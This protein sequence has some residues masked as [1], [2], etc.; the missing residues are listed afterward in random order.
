MN[1]RQRQLITISHSPTPSDCA[2]SRRDWPPCLPFAFYCEDSPNAHSLT[3]SDCAT[4]HPSTGLLRGGTYSLGGTVKL[5]L[6][7][8]RHPVLNQGSSPNVVEASLLRSF[9][10]GENPFLPPLKLE[11]SATL[12]LFRQQ[13]DF[14]ILEF[15]RSCVLIFL[16]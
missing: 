16:K 3:P 9:I 5:C 15:L 13:A 4:H 11:A 1:N 10:R 7:V 14:Y 2:T 12:T 6:A 8:E